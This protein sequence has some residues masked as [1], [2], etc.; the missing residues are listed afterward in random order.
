LPKPCNPREL[1]ARVRVVLRRATADGGEVFAFG[2]WR[3]DTAAREL[4]S[5]GEQ[6]V[7]LTPNEFRLLETLVRARRKVLSRDDLADALGGTTYEAFDRA[8]DVT[9]SRLRRKL[10]DHDPRDVI[11]TVRGD[12]Y[13]LVPEVTS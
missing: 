10:A 12:G 2:G 3:L 4:R 7:D 8:I 13:G 9:V 5:P 1:L 11:R 6:P